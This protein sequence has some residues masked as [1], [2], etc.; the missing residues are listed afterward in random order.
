MLVSTFL[1]IADEKPAQ[2][3]LDRVSSQ[4]GVLIVLLAD[5][6]ILAVNTRKKRRHVLYF[7]ICSVSVLVVVLAV[8]LGTIMLRPFTGAHAADDT[9]AKNGNS[10]AITDATGGAQKMSTGVLP[11]RPMYKMATRMSPGA[12]MKQSVVPCLNKMTAPLCY[13]PRQIRLAYGMQVLINA[14]FTGKGR[15]ITIIDAF[16]SPTLRKDLHLFD[17]LFGLNDPQLNI[18]T[19]F[20]LTPFNANDAAQIGFASEISLDVEWAHAMAPDATIDLVLGNVKT[21][22]VQGQAM[23]LLQATNYAVQHNL[24]SVISQSFGV[25]ENCL[26][27]TTLQSGHRTFQKARAQQQTVFASAGDMGAAAIQ[28]DGNG[29]P[30]TLAQGVNYPAS[31]P[32]VS[33]VGGTT[34]RL[35]A[36]G[37]YQSESAWNE[38]LQGGGA[39]GGGAS[40]VFALP[41][42]QANVINSTHRFSTDLSFDGDSFTGVPVVTSSTKPGTTLVLPF[43]GTSV[44]S[45]LAAGMIAL[46][47]QMMGKRVGFLNSA[48]YR[49]NNSA[50]YAQA[51]HDVKTGNNSFI[52]QQNNGDLVAVQGFK[53][54]THWDPPTGVGSPQA[55]GL[56]QLLPRFLTANDGANL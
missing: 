8:L 48:F 36:A 44:G 51:F 12:Q 7:V 28:C 40:K 55:S 3:E 14:G 17:Q 13:S 11:I 56:A 15:I 34:L 46:I 10:P 53:T 45:P 38:S 54:T 31:D 18:I 29:N 33:S 25:G 4:V 21:E 16:Q 35:S 1:L 30:V 23:A 43:G 39:T 27:K 41:A 49:I 19:P 37:D 26:S 50:V 32:L 9:S 6:E 5:E 52:F 2:C 47:D 42:F 20:G 22:S 24:G